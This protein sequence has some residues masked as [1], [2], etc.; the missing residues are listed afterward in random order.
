M[1]ASLIYSVSRAQKLAEW[2]KDF[3]YLMTDGGELDSHVENSSDVRVSRAIKVI[4][5]ADFL[6]L[7]VAGGVI[8]ASY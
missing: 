7:R 4:A 8:V 1:T 3:V 2:T 6:V 5:L